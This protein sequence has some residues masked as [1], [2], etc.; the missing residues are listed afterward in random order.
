MISHGLTIVINELKK[1]LESVYGV[2]V[3]NDV[4][5]CGNLSEGLASGSNGP[6]VPRDKLVIQLVNVR[7]E[8]S[9][10]NLPNLVRNDAN[11]RAASEN[12]PAFLN[13][14]I[15]LTATHTGY[16]NAL[17]ML[18]R[19]IR[20]FQAINVFTQDT[21]E[22]SSITTGAPANLPDRLEEFRISF[23]LY[24]PSMEEINHLWGTLGGRQYP[25][26]LYGMRMPDLKFRGIQGESG[27]ITGV[28]DVFSRKNPGS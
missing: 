8:K 13:F 11:L 16:T 21:V 25:F 15:L 19:A 2:P 22:P 1:H 6:G 26:V 3:I 28:S 27:H 4:V 20:F 7:E 14:M 17:I 10:K 18:S 24:T 5:V 23:D 9:L 12:P